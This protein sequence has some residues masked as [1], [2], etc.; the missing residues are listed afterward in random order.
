[1]A[2]EALGPRVQTSRKRR[3]FRSAGGKV[4]S[5]L[6]FA[7]G[8]TTN[9]INL[10]LKNLQGLYQQHWVIRESL[11]SLRRGLLYA[12]VSQ[13][14]AVSTGAIEY[15]SAAKR[16]PKQKE[17]RTVVHCALETP[18][19]QAGTRVWCIICPMRIPSMLTVLLRF[20]GAPHPL[21]PPVGATL[22]SV[23]GYSAAFARGRAHP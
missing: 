3:T 16:P 20:G 17:A 18:E 2:D 13:L 8:E 23:Q 4:G 6:G 10:D 11:I 7:P 21:L 15:V 9:F 12:A 14:P 1:M 19:P 5:L 22:A